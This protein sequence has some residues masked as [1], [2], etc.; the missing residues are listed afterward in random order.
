MLYRQY[1]PFAQTGTHNYTVSKS[2][3]DNLDS[4]G[5]NAE[6][7]AWYGVEHATHNWVTVNHPAVTHEEAYQSYELVESYGMCLK[8][9][10]RL[11]E[12]GKEP[13]D[14][15]GLCPM[16]KNCLASTTTYEKYGYVTKYKTVTDK[17]A[18]SETYC[19]ECN[20]VK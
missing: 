16:D 13:S 11:Y 1:N 12:Y 8:H 2:E 19:S 14:W 6:G 7:T 17:D 5:W 20:A 10:C 3:N 15:L 4:K 18:Y 9:K